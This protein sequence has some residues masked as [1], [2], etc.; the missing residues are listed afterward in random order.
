M[1]IHAS[2]SLPF[3][4]FLFFFRKSSLDTHSS[5]VFFCSQFISPVP[6]K[7]TKQVSMRRTS[8]SGAQ[9]RSNSSSSSMQRLPAAASTALPPQPLL[10]RHGL[11]A[12]PRHPC[13]NSSLV[14]LRRPRLL[15]LECSASSGGNGS[16]SEKARGGGNNGDGSSSSR[17]STSTSA[18]PLPVPAPRPPST[19]V[20]ADLGVGEFDAFKEVSR[21]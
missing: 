8:L 2:P 1:T 9:A 16:G 15:G 14:M 20:E 13:S 18:N 4:F 19:R 6:T 21:E 7:K 10:I 12:P 3:F 17:I 5:S 11:A